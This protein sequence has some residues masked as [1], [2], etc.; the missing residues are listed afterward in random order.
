MDKYLGES[1]PKLGFGLMRLPIK[2]DVIDM[3]QMKKMVDR[4]LEEGFCYFD[5]AYGYH[6]GESEKAIKEALVDRY[7]REKYLLATKLPAWAGAKSKEEAEQMFYTSLERTGAGYFDF[8]LLHNLG[9][10]RSH[11]FDDYDIWS[12]LAERKKEGLIKHLGFSMHDKADVLDEILSAHPEMEF[13]QLQINYADWEDPTIESRKCYEV[14]RKHGKP[15]IIMEP[16]KG[17]TLANPPKEVA[18][19]LKQANPTASP[20]S[21]A[22]R[23]A[24]SLD[25]IIT[26]L[27]GMSNLEQME[28]NLSYMKAFKPLSEE[29]RKVVEKAREIYNSFPKVPCTACAYCMKG[30]PQNIAIYGSFQAYNISS[31]YGDLK[32]ARNKYTWNTDGQG[33]KK[34]SACISCGKCE[35]VCPQHIAIREELKKVAETLE[36]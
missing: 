2:D 31:M 24:A 28:D 21:W 4:F 11:Y 32:S 14:A 1:I 36:G 17:G 30:C 29:E 25:G 33:R 9:E 10:G 35:Q 8:F 7:P 12:F 16:V 13:V 20:S 27:S 23:F 15:V 6:N 3:E 19:V 26:V 34:A 5:T 18:D 22:I